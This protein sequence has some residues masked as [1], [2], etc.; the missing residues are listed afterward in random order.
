MEFK[1]FIDNHYY[2]Y[3]YDEYVYYFKYDKQYSNYC[4]N[5][6]YL[7]AFYEIKIFN[8]IIQYSDSIDYGQA[9]FPLETETYNYYSE[10]YLSEFVH[11]LPDN[12]IDKIN[13][14][15]KNRIKILL[16]DK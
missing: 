16:N 1:D 2:K 9:Y 13:Y 5:I 12:N 4:D 8:N 7:N 3:I 14:N 15:R 10:V 11:L 6:G